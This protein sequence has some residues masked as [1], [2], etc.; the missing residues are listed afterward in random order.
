[1]SMPLPVRRGFTLVELLATIAIIGLLIALLL[2]AVQ[3]ARESGRRVA[4]SNNLRQIG[5]GL[6]HFHASN[7]SLPVTTSALYGVRGWTASD[8]RNMEAV[9]WAGANDPLWAEYQAVYGQMRKNAS[10]SIVFAPY[11]WV[12]GI[13][14]F[15]EQTTRF[16]MFRL[17]RGC[18]DSLNAPAMRLPLSTIICPS[19]PDSA[20][21]SMTGR[22]KNPSR[23]GHGLWYL[24][25]MGPVHVGGGNNACP[26]GSTSGPNAWCNLSG[27]NRTG[28]VGLFSSENWTPSRFEQV[29]DGVSKTIMLFET[30]PRADGHNSAFY[31]PV[32]TLAIPTNAPVPAAAYIA[33]DTNTEQ[34]NMAQFVNGPRS[35]HPG[36]CGFLMCDASVQFFAETTDF[37][38]LCQLGTKAGCENVTVP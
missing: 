7:R 20:R 31:A 22:C 9:F 2:P 3:S 29:S 6:Q 24:G 38:T 26:A 35:N 15:I 17:D 5:L 16:N 36:A 4:C 1:M 8:G 18:E 19:D 23:T 30:T 27:N 37:R 13:L 12:T 21:P 14:P 33:Y 32:G 10:G 11:T 28:K 34:G 25:S